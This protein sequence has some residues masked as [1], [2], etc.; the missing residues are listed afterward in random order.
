M[1]PALRFRVWMPTRIASLALLCLFS[2][3]S[4]VASDTPDPDTVTIGGDLQE[5]LGCPG[6][7]QPDCANTYLAFDMDDQVWQ[8]VFTVPA[9]SWQYKATLNDSWVENYGMNATL[10]GGNI[11]LDL[12]GPTDVKFYYSHE[13]HWVTDN[14]NSIIAVAGGSFQSELGCSGDWQPG[15]L[16]SWLQD[17]DADGIYTFRTRGLPA[18]DYETKVGISEDWAENYGAGGVPGGANIPFTVPSDCVEMLFSF[19]WATKV[20]TVGVAP[21]MPQ[22]AQV[23]MAGSFQ[24]ELGCPGDWQPDCSSTHLAFDAEDQVWQEVFSVPAGDW[25]YKAALNDSWDVNYGQNATLNG[26]NIPLSLADPTDVKFYYSHETHWVTDNVNSL[27]ASA[28]GSYQSELGCSG[29]WQPWCLRSWLQDPDNDGVFS[30]SARLPA[31]NYDVKVGIDESW[32]LNYGA[33]GVQNGPNITFTVPQACTEMLFRFTSADNM[34]TVGVAGQ[35]I[36]TSTVVTSSLNPSS[37]GDP[38]TFTAEVSPATATGDVNFFDGATLLGTESLVSGSAALTIST[39][40]AGSHPIT[41]SYGGDGGHAV[42]DSAELTQVVNLLSTTVGLTVSPDQV[43]IGH[44]VTFSATVSPATAT[45]TIDFLVNGGLVDTVA[46]VGDTASTSLVFDDPGNMTVVAIYS[47]D[48]NHLPG[49]SVG[50]ALL[51]FGEIPTLNLEMIAV[52]IV[53]LMGAG[54]WF[55]RSGVH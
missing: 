32:D 10:G 6:D 48:S 29:D 37:Y 8:E 9:G 30:F 38:V 18:G 47:G 41:A 54:V 23:T 52:L 4:L 13:T 46:L 33:G 45:G 7:W 26:P 1:T 16:R 17:L 15:C 40:A 34:L 24:E 39:F 42:S 12:A 43:P 3:G 14:V 19:D 21:L 44:P 2:A 27:I 5:E 11:P 35:G 20:L 31:G 51:A 22:P 50:I 28:P 55:L 49:S 25:E 53:L 36:A